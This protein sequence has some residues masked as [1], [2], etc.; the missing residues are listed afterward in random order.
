MSEQ[1]K[2]GNW[3]IFQTYPH[4]WHLHP[5]DELM[6][7]HLGTTCTCE[8]VNKPENG[9]DIIVHNSFN[10]RELIEQVLETLKTKS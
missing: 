2:V 1:M 10:Q 9:I 7:I 4:E 8:P 3:G 6:H 5:A